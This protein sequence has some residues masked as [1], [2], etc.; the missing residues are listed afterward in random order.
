V[1]K[2]RFAAVRERGD[3][4]R[5]SSS[6]VSDDHDAIA[7]IPEGAEAV[8]HQ[9]FSVEQPAAMHGRPASGDSAA[10]ARR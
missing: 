10:A 4:T 9:P 8:R 6:L 2:P 7:G 3:L 1:K 5:R